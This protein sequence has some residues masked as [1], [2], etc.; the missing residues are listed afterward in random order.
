VCVEAACGG[1]ACN[2]AGSN[3]SAVI[4]SVA[5]NLPNNE[6]PPLRV[7]PVGMTRPSGDKTVGR[8]PFSVGRLKIF[9]FISYYFCCFCFSSFLLTP[10]PSPEGEGSR[11]SPPRPWERAGGVRTTARRPVPPPPGS[12]HA[13]PRLRLAWGYEKTH[14]RSSFIHAPGVAPRA[15]LCLPFR[16]KTHHPSS[17]IIRSVIFMSRFST[18]VKNKKSVQCSIFAAPRLVA[19]QELCF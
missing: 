6:M 1:V 7:A 14:H 5:R 17:F 15:R 8:F 11:I 19:K 3:N 12:P 2:T 4:P 16:Q 18:E 10:G 13:A 9:V